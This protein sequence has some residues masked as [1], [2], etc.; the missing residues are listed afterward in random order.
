[1]GPKLNYVLSKRLLSGLY[2][3]S[4]SSHPFMYVWKTCDANPTFTYPPCYALDISTELLKG[5]E[6]VVIA[7]ELQLSMWI[8]VHGIC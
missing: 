4:W 8:A 5:L 6:C 7:M 2:L 3:G 1:M